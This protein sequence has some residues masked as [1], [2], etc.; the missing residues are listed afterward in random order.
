MTDTSRRVALA[1]AAKLTEKLAT[2]AE[3]YTDAKAE[4]I[5]RN[6][7]ATE[8]EASYLG[9]LLALGWMVMIEASL[10]WPKEVA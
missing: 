2:G 1:L 3:Q 10:G 8:E 5:F 9:C 7:G 4:A 6:A